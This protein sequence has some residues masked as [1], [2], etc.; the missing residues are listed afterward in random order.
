MSQ[1]WKTWDFDEY[2]EDYDGWVSSDDPVYEC[3]DRVLD[4]VVDLAA[5]KPRSHVLDIATGTGNLAIRMI[6]RDARVLGLDPSRRMLAKAHHKIGEDSRVELRHAPDPFLHL[7]Y[8]DN[9]FDAV[10]S[11]YSFHHVPHPMQPEGIREMI[12]VLKPGCPWVLGD[13][14]FET[15][16]AERAALDRHEWLEDEYFPRIKALRPVFSSLGMEIET[17]Q[18]T[19]ITWVLWAPKPVGQ[20]A[21]P[22]D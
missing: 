7:E 3:Y 5:I 15:E 10:V 14:I 17:R 12:R 16:E 19:P 11:T 8:P 20:E 18:F 13:L 4:F 9:H 6:A 2:A 1:E 22:G 21:S